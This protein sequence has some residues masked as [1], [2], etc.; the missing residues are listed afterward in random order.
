MTAFQWILNWFWTEGSSLSTQFYRHGASLLAGIWTGHEPWLRPICFGAAW[1][2][3]L[4][5]GANFFRLFQE[6]QRRVE[7]LHQIPCADCQYFTNDMHLKCTVHPTIALSE[8]AIDCSD[9]QEARDW[10]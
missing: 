7:T 8:E 1:V 2:T 3:V 9:F 10:G 5:L 4:T 6:G